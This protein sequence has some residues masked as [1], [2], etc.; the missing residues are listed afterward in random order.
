[1]VFLLP[2]SSKN[3]RKACTAKNTVFHFNQKMWSFS[4]SP[5]PNFSTHFY[6]ITNVGAVSFSTSNKDGIIHELGISRRE[7]LCKWEAVKVVWKVYQLD[8][9]EKA[10]FDSYHKTERSPQLAQ[11]KKGDRLSVTLSSS[12]FPSDHSLSTVRKRLFSRLS[13]FQIP[14]CNHF[15]RFATLNNFRLY[16]IHVYQ[17]SKIRLSYFSFSNISRF[18]RT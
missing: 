15:E 14:Q 13:T 9:L 17:T 11:F 5:L 3:G 4:Q 2:L 6:I 1:M 7:K 12:P 10:C 18:Y 8:G 16:H